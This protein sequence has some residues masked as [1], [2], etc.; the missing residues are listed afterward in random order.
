MGCGWADVGLRWVGL[1]RV[2]LGRIGLNCDGSN[3]A[4]SDWVGMGWVCLCG[5]GLGWVGYPLPR[6]Q[7]VAPFLWR[8]ESSEAWRA[9]E[10]TK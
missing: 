3:W 7:R 10:T 2:L 1:D 6:G 8:M 5:M 4:R 9:C